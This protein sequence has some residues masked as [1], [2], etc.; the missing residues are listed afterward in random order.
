MGLGLDLSTPRLQSI[1]RT[2]KTPRLNPILRYP[3]S[4]PAPFPRTNP[5]LTLRRA[6]KLRHRLRALN[7]C[8]GFGRALVPAPVSNPSTVVGLEPRGGGRR[9]LEV[10]EG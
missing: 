5:R 10:L 2:L 7:Q 8:H 9:V 1:E 3:E 4:K 6:R